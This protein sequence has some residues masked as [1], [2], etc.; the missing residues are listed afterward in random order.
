MGH[1]GNLSL[2]LV[3][4][5][6][7]EAAE[8]L[9]QLPAWGPSELLQDWP[10]LYGGIFHLNVPTVDFYFSWAGGIESRRE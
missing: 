10:F 1:S 7:L 2:L 3:S 6:Q 5:E 9:S 4:T 8:L